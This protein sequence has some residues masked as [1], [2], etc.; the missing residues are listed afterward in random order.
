M[1][2]NQ[3]QGSE[4]QKNSV[5]RGENYHDTTCSNSINFHVAYICKIIARLNGIEKNKSNSKSVIEDIQTKVAVFNYG[6]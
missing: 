5:I 4:N 1:P 3:T 6:L 2:L